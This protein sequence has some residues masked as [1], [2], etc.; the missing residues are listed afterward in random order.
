MKPSFLLAYKNYHDFMDESVE[1]YL[2][3]AWEHDRMAFFL[4]ELPTLLGNATRLIMIGYSMPELI[5]ILIRLFS[6]P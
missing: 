4:Q 3:F 1:I 2:Q 6:E 5:R